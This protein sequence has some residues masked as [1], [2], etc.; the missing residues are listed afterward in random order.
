MQF[1]LQIV[2]ICSL[3]ITLTL[4]SCR[5]LDDDTEFAPRTQ[6]AF[7]MFT[8]LAGS[9]VTQ[10]TDTTG[11]VENWHQQF[12]LSNAQ[13]GDISLNEDHMWLSNRSEGE[14]LKVDLRTE[15]IVERYSTQGIRPDILEVG[16]DYAMFQDA[17]NL[18]IGFFNLKSNEIFAVEGGSQANFLK[19]NAGKF[20]LIGDSTVTIYNEQALTAINELQADPT[21]V[22]VLFNRLGDLVLFSCVNDDCKQYVID[23]N[24]DTFTANSPLDRNYQRIAISP[25]FKEQYGREYLDDLRLQNGTV[26]PIGITDVDWMVVDYFEGNLYY[27]E[28][29]NQVLNIYNLHTNRNF[30]FPNG[31]VPTEAPK[32]YFYIDYEAN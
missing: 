3:A 11:F 12:G 29:N 27:E 10:V 17:I 21:F 15:Q 13:L 30:L 5:A 31:M 6:S 25:F 18:R 4:F 26:E 14:L 24:G 23:G 7:F 22:Q 2:F 9:H 32:A 20:Y 8:D 28:G 16:A 1:R 19:Y